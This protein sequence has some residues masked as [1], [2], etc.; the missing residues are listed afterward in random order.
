MADPRDLPPPPATLLDGAS[1]FLDFDGTLVELA[2]RPEAVAVDAALAGLLD[3]LAER[4]DGRVVL[5]SG[6]SIQQ[7]DGFLEEAGAM[8]GFVGSHGAET[9]LAGG[10]IVRP[11]RPA[12]LDAAARLFADAFRGRDG[13]V[14]EAKSL[15]VG[16]HYRLDPS[17]E[18]EAHAIAEAFAAAND[19]EVQHGKMMVELRLPGHDK[20]SAIAAL[21][22]R[23]PFAGHPPVFL[24][25]DLTDE[26]GFVAA[27]AHGGAGILVGAARETT[28]RY[29]LDGVAAV[30]GWLGGAA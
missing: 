4:L 16:L 11:D 21:M 23:A 27:A 22:D 9:R 6:R 17:A 18:N 26:P 14:I 25:D 30:R 28:A 8:L 20:G 29:R 1:L 10:A 19:L 24:G 15:G 5:V 12:S 13:V 3:R 7:L 2:E